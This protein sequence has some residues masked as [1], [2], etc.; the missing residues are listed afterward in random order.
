MNAPSTWRQATPWLAAI[1]LGVVA[2]LTAVGWWRASEATATDEA[3]AAAAGRAVT[4]LTTW[5]ADSLADVEA[6]VA[7]FG[8]T[9][10][11]EEAAR[12]F[13]ETAAGLQQADVTSQGEILDIAIADV[14]GERAVALASVRQV[15]TNAS[16]AN[17]AESCW[18]A[19]ATLALVN[20]RWLVDRLELFGPNACDGGSG[21]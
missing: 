12:T 14:V 9:R 7:D 2:L 6:G 5:D 17:P 3:I 21:A 10:F 16:V 15:V 20:G 11:Q 1:A 19:R 8:T 13:A 4:A 18:G